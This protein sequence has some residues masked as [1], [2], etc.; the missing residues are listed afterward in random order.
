MSPRCEP[1]DQSGTLS[2]MSDPIDLATE[3]EGTATKRVAR[4]IAMP[5][6]PFAMLAR[7]FLF[8][9][10]LLRAEATRLKRV[11][12]APRVSGT[13][14]APKLDVPKVDAPKLDVPKVDV[15]KPDVPKLVPTV[16]GDSRP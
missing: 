13:T 7:L 3:R 15:P 9:A 2:A 4:I 1:R 6:E 10:A 12:R 8:D 16:R 5:F 14:T 11:R